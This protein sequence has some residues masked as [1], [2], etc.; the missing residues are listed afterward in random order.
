MR[1]LFIRIVFSTALVAVMG[2][3]AGGASAQQMPGGPTL[4]VANPSPGDMITPGSLMIQGVAFDPTAATGT[5]VDRVSVFLDD[6][7]GGGMHLGDATLGMPNVMSSQPADA[8]WMLVT[9]ALKGAGADHML[10][11][12]ARSSV[13][14]QET[15]IEIPVSV[16]QQARSTVPMAHFDTQPG[17]ADS[18]S[19]SDNPPN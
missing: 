6:R 17:G 10:C 9:P 5:G 19:I 4:V 7:D 1:F 18:G 12:Y 2:L 11:V 3:A 13:T 16:G 8:G 15:E 14:G